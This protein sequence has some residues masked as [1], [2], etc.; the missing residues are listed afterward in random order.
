MT[1]LPQVPVVS[2]IPGDHTMFLPRDLK[3]AMHPIQ[4]SKRFISQSVVVKLFYIVR[5]FGH[6][7]Q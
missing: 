6:G 4:R 3:R 1:G 5:G 2:L 7:D